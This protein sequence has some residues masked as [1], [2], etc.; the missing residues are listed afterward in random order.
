M[1]MMLMMMAAGAN[2]GGNPRANHLAQGP[3]LLLLLSQFAPRD[4]WSST[5][6]WWWIYKK[7]KPKFGNTTTVPPPPFHHHHHQMFCY[8]SRRQRWLC[9]TSLAWGEQGMVGDGETR[10]SWNYFRNI[11]LQWRLSFHP[12]Q[13]HA[14]HVV[15]DTPC[16]LDNHNILDA[17][18]CVLSF[19][20]WLDPLNFA[21]K[22]FALSAR[23][24]VTVGTQGA[25]KCG[26]WGQSR[27]ESFHVLCRAM[28]VQELL[29]GR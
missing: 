20:L 29:E 12:Y 13:V 6:P 1:V 24:L 10:D 18:C 17:C 14:D 21:L 4:H 26:A 27:S 5:W 8:A 11:R 9:G 7:M 2:H 22:C 15:L 25:I 19:A 28:Q 16:V 3:P 23:I